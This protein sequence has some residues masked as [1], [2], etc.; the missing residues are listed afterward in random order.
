MKGSRRL[1]LGRGSVPSTTEAR[2]AIWRRYDQWNSALAAVAEQQGAGGQPLYLQLDEDVLQA[3]VGHM[4]EEIK[5][6]RGQ[7]LALVRVTLDIGPHAPP[8]RAHATRTQAWK[9][10]FGRP[11]PCLALLYVCSA[12]AMEMRAGDGMSSANYYG[13]LGAFLGLDPYEVSE[14]Q[15]GYRQ[16][17]E[18]LWRSVNQWL[19]YHEGEKGLPTAFALRHRYAGLPMSQALV[20]RGDRARLNRFF[21]TYGL[22]PNGHMAPADLEPVLDDWITSHPCPVSSFLRELWD[23]GE[24]RERIAGVVAVELA[25]WDGSTDLP[26]SDVKRSGTIR[27]V[28]RLR[29]FPV[30]KLELDL[31]V[32]LGHDEDEAVLDVIDGRGACQQQVLFARAGDGSLTIASH[33]EVDPTALVAG[34][35]RLRGPTATGER[36]P[37]LL[38]TLRKDELLQA[39][40]ESDRVQLGETSM[41]LAPA[42]RR[43][44]V[45]A[46]LADCAAPGWQ[47]VDDLPGLPSGWVLFNAVEVF[48]P[49]D[50]SKHPWVELQ[51]LMPL[52][53]TQLTW[54]GGLRLPT[55][56]R[57]WSTFRPP[58]LRAVL[59]HAQSA[60]VVMSSLN[61]D[62]WSETWQSDDGVI[63]IDVAHVGLDDGDYAAQLRLPGKRDAVAEV[64]LRLRSADTPNRIPS[65]PDLGYESDG[66]GAFSAVE[67][68]AVRGVV[69]QTIEPGTTDGPLPPPRLDV[70][71]IRRVRARVSTPR[72]P[73]V[74]GDI[75]D[76]SCVA[77][78]AHR[79]VLP[80]ATGDAKRGW[81]QG[82]CASCGLT[83]RFPASHAQAVKKNK[84]A[85]SAR[86]DPVNLGRLRAAPLQDEVD[87]QLGFDALCH[88]GRG[89]ASALERIALQLEPSKLFADTFTRTLV[90]LGYL[91]LQRNSRN[92]RPENWQVPPPAFVLTRDGSWFLTGW[93][94][95]SLVHALSLRAEQY[96][97]HIRIA[98]GE[99]LPDSIVLCDAD[100]D[101]ANKISASAEVDGQH[102]L[103]VPDAASRLVAAVPRLASVAATLPRVSMGEVQKVE[104]WDPETA[105]W[106]EDTQPGSGFLRLHGA[107]RTYCLR[108]SSDV[109]DGVLRP[110]TPQLLKHVA[111]AL[112]GRPL[113]AWDRDSETLM[114]PKGCD[115]PG[116][117]G[118]AATLCSGQAPRV[119]EDGQALLYVHVPEHIARAVNARLGGR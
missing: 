23:Q 115:L 112:V 9:P 106:E 101:T 59:P 77:T 26:A 98:K 17:A 16:H 13:R 27:L 62:V 21:A 33:D 55:K 1:V 91:D 53:A 76:A 14:L 15:R 113:V 22:P 108:T 79:I 12:A 60:E 19:E 95:P 18:A 58:E 90:A 69:A 2:L 46:A 24:A 50:R 36:K 102:A 84:G 78:G 6:P 93:R 54:A 100:E 29:R 63:V 42:D 107:V 51:A 85:K 86:K 41:L 80:T 72:R 104:R 71:I 3:A 119:S 74:L 40:V 103:V 30:R 52:S 65:Q 49:I 8:L 97:A 87:W 73:L 48:A 94:S 110:L 35:T 57:K 39:Y 109:V 4:G 64:H 83:R 32:R 11:P 88:V 20:R 99:G 61:D 67:N 96:G 116:L 81:V 68:G 34:F 75:N 44:D 118:R 37:R 7:L 92:W 70:L 114:V 111:G 89:A 47:L 10:E 31:S 28:A 66:V 105:R 117:L 45:S 43:T 82:V 38:V 25:E 5:D 56:L